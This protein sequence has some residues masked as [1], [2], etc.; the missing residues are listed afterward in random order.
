[1]RKAIF[2]L[3]LLAA[4]VGAFPQDVGMVSRESKYSV[5]ETA[6]RLEKAIQASG[7]Y[8]IFLRMDHAANAKE[9]GASLRPSQLILFGNP[10]GGAPLLAEAPTLGLDLPNRA[11]VWE[12]A[13]GKV[14]LTYNDV[15]QTL[16]RHGVKRS[17]EQ[18]K[19]IDDRQKVLFDKAVD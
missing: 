1:M 9:V 13:A 3:A 4:S 19:V 8:K 17:D 14:W 18:L 16:G 6:D 2:G 12:D 5:V 7:T 10:K 11:L 15:R